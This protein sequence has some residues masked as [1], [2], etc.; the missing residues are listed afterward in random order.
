MRTH[1][2]IVGGGLAG[3]VA[4]IAAREA[5]LD[6]TL[7]EAH[8]QLGGRARTAPGAYRANWGPHVIYA[9]GPLWAWLDRRGLARPVHRFPAQ[10]RI[11]FRAGGRARLLPPAAVSKG[12]LR[13]RNAQAPVDRS[14]SEWATER[15]KDQ[16]A[17]PIAAFMAV[18]TFDY[19]PGRLSAA[20]VT[21]QLR[22]AT[23]FPPV[24]RYFP[25]GWVTLTTRLASRA[26]ELGARIETSSPVTCL[27][28]APVILA[29]P[30]A[31]AAKLLGDPSLTWTGT[32]TALLDIAVTRRR[33]DPLI[34]S[35]L[36]QPGFAENYSIPDRDVA[37]AGETL[38]QS[39]TGIRPDEDL[40]QAVARLET[41]LDA[42]YVGWSDR[43]TW[44]R[45]LALDGETGA[46]DLPGT[47]WR[48]RPA[49]DRGDDVHIAGDMV[50][51]PGLLSEVSHQ[52][53]LMAV[54]R[55]T[56]HAHAHVEWRH[57]GRYPG[58]PRT[59]VGGAGQQLGGES[60]EQPAPRLRLPVPRDGHAVPHTTGRPAKR[61]W[62][63]SLTARGRGSRSPALPPGSAGTGLAG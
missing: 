18:T 36:D 61:R 29:V 14:F 24:V 3:L 42:S 10:A 55:L 2:T 60:A 20:F 17:A 50:A 46:V 56:A 9:D 39:Q 53:A 58:Y 43:L 47:T 21:R 8:G 62:P 41:F 63:S 27:P 34:L 7:Y 16:A 44:R 48:D 33:Q 49:G 15:L 35:D 19:D 57:S 22:R 11:A 13:S 12:I 54:A 26:R 1:L 37:P 6:V 4:A 5:G 30:L 31:Q 40:G 59:E 28:P 32:R 38:I 25:G 23:S 52:S 51:A 45:Q